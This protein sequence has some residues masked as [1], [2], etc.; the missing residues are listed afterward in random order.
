MIVKLVASPFCEAHRF[1]G[2]R[3]ISH[4]GDVLKLYGCTLSS[5]GARTTFPSK[6]TLMQNYLDQARKFC[7]AKE[8]EIQS[9]VIEQPI[10]WDKLSEL[11]G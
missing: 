4:N 7:A 10:T 8:W 9:Q 1:F 5:L 3:I 6:L 11:L 2:V